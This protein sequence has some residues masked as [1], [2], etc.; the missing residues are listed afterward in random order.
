MWHSLFSTKSYIF[1]FSSRIEYLKVPHAHVVQTFL[2]LFLKKEIFK[3]KNKKYL[4]NILRVIKKPF[5]AQV[6]VCGLYY[7]DPLSCQIRETVKRSK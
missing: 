3:N 6:L 1:F 7:I 2:F 4:W 5:Y